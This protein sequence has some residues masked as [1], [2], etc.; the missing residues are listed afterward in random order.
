MIP[1]FENGHGKGLGY[2]FKTFS[3]RFESICQEHLA[4][5]HAG[6][7]AFIFYDFTNK[8]LS[9]ILEDK[10][11]FAQLDRLAGTRLSIFY[12]HAGSRATVEAF[13]SKFLSVLGIAEK[14]SLPCVVFFK[15]V[16]DRIEDIAVAQLDN[17][18]IIHGFHELYSVIERNQLNEGEGAIKWAKIGQSSSGLKF[19]V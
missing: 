1:I 15:I 13:N 14:V 9:R 3:A 8:D 11:V 2:T 7:F 18:D 12:L 4:D 16:N 5:K 6:A 10:D 19:F 17:A